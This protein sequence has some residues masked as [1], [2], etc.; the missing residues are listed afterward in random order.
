MGTVRRKG[1][2]GGVEEASCHIQDGFDLQ[3]EES[4]TTLENEMA[5]GGMEG[6][7]SSFSLGRAASE[8]MGEGL[9]VGLVGGRREGTFLGQGEGCEGAEPTRGQ[10]I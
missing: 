8:D 6:G 10:T 4:S 2:A 9:N 7:A 1:L 5:T 3:M